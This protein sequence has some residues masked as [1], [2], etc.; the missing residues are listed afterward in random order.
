ML[1]VA[2]S[3]APPSLVILSPGA[4]QRASGNCHRRQRRARMVHRRQLR[5]AWQ[6]LATPGF[7][8][9]YF[10]CRLPCL[11]RREAAERPV[12]A[13]HVGRASSCL[14]PSG[15][16]FSRPQRT[17]CDGVAPRAGGTSKSHLLSLAA[18][19][20]GLARHLG[21]RAANPP[22]DRRHAPGV[23]GSGLVRLATGSEGGSLL[24]YSLAFLAAACFATYSALRAKFAEGP[25]DAA[26]AACGV[27]ALIEETRAA[28]LA[29][30]GLWPPLTLRQAQGEGERFQELNLIL[31]LSGRQRRPQAAKDGREQKPQTFSTAR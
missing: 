4:A 5:R 11:H 3:A 7:S 24:G 26:G 20:G 18:S 2:A 23:R 8:G 27:A 19:H 28:A 6:C 25:P 31:S 29:L 9:R 1:Q 10:R 15:T 30:G 16:R 17:L 14:L 12:T 22:A 13:W 21:R